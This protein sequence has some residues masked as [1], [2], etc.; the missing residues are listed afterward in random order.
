MNR[1]NGH[2]FTLFTI[3]AII[4]LVSPCV[5]AQPDTVW[6]FRVS[7]AGNPAFYNAIECSDGS[8]ILAGET[9]P[10]LAT[11]NFLI[12]RITSTGTVEWTRT[13]G[14][15]NG[16]AAYAGVEH[17]NGNVILAGSGNGGSTVLLM[18]IGPDGDSLW[19]RTYGNGSMTSAYDIVLLLDGN[20]GVVGS[21]L[22]LDSV[23]S[24]LW[25]LKCD[26]S[27]DTLWTRSYGGNDH[28]IGYHISER[29]DR[30]LLIGGCSR[31]NGAGD[32]DVW[33][34]SCDSLG[35]QLSSS[36]Y[37]GTGPEIGYDCSD[38]DSVLYL[39]GKM[40]VA[41]QNRGYLVKSSSLGDSLWTRALSAGGTEEQ[42]R[43][44]VSRR[45]GGAICAGWSGP[46]WNERRC[47]LL[48]IAA[49]GSDDWSWIFGPEASGLY[50]IIPV[51][52]GGYLA[53]GQ[54]S[55]SN[56]RK[57]YALRLTSSRV[58]G[59]V[60]ENGSETPVVG[61]RIEIIDSQM[62]AITDQDG[63]Y[64]LNLVNGS[65]DMTV[66]GHCNSRDTL[67]NVAIPPDTITTVDFHVDRP[68]FVQ[69]ESSLNVV[70][71]NH[72]ETWV[73]LRIANSGTGAMEVGIIPQPFQPSSD[74][75]RV[76]PDTALIPPGDTL[77]VQVGIAP[78]TTDDGAFDFSGGLL[79]L[80]NSCPGDS[81][82][83]SIMAY[84]LDTDVNLTAVPSGFSLSAHPNPFNPTTTLTFSIPQTVL[85]KLTVHDI[86]GRLIALL[87]EGV[88]TPGQYRIPFDAKRLPSG[89]Y[90][91]RL[92]SDLFHSIQKIML[93]R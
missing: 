15:L 5:Y 53:Y 13:Y 16:D 20:V 48:A 54:I 7:T 36:L 35:N 92:E 27:G 68:Q 24:D 75:L 93:V 52:A 72:T 66:S 11:S 32:Y 42:L 18:G 28:D 57:G 90:F 4:S 44:V 25:F 19:S 56:V 6:S 37:G 83:I 31:G 3:F 23:H 50:G 12:A 64:Q 91:A 70:V 62:Y 10:G 89:L 61:A 87:A 47:W 41:G 43:G 33:L 1:N 22:E 51:S 79:I 30:N 49:D 86:T 74:W 82:T 17:P 39:G 78:D 85:V 14:G 60:I 38:G 73:P 26:T 80:T 58:Q 45:L 88:F 2:N 63:H 40:V 71:Q 46:S 65:Y 84:V 76:V 8:F 29:Q 59:S 77:T 21:K 55:E 69:F 67:L 9:N 34:L 81:V